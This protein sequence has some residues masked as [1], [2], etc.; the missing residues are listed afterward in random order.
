MIRTVL[1]HVDSSAV[2][3]ACNP[4]EHLLNTASVS[5]TISSP[6]VVAHKAHEAIALANLALVRSDPE[7]FAANTCLFSIDE[8]VQELACLS[9]S[10]GAMLMECTTI[11]KGRN[12]A[13]L[14]EISTRTGMH[15]VMGSSCQVIVTYYWCYKRECPHH[16]IPDEHSQMS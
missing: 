4:H 3:G 7:R 1:G 15:V 6:K 11:C 16:L 2:S 8:A 9:S 5:C 10:G 13:G 12:P 14:V